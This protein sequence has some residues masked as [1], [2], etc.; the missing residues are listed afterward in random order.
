MFSLVQHHK[1]SINDV[2]ELLPFEREIFVDLL[3][4]YLEREKEEIEKRQ[5]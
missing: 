1:Y 4:S 2:E 3:V 5:Q